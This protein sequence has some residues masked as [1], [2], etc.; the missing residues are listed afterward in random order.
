M[1]AHQD[2]TLVDTERLIA[3]LRHQGIG[4]LSG[5][6]D[7]EL[8]QSVSYAPLPFDELLRRLAMCPESRVRNAV[9]SLLLLHPERVNDV[10]QALEES[11]T[12]TGESL[13]VLMLAALY[14]QELWRTRLTFALGRHKELPTNLFADLWKQRDL[15][16]PATFHGELGLLALQAA[17]QSR[18]GT[19]FAYRGDWQNQVD[20]LLAQYELDRRQRKAV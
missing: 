13:A 11:D 5:G 16:E 14:L 4:Y 15:P 18:Y 9:I 6:Q 1:V 2:K 12:E 20:R 10:I 17:E 7:P 8:A 19:A 3:E